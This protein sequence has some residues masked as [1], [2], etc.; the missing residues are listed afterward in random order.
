MPYAIRNVLLVAMSN[1]LGENLN[2]YLIGNSKLITSHIDAIP[3]AL[4]LSV[5]TWKLTTISK[6][7]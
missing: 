1:R 7:T 4:S 5:T 2:L 3:S 6:E